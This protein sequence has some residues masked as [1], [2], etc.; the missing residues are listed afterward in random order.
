MNFFYTIG[1]WKNGTDAPGILSINLWELSPWIPNVKKMISNLFPKSFLTIC[2]LILI[3]GCT[4]A[5]E[6]IAYP[7]TDLSSA[8]LIPKPLKVVPTGSAFGLDNKTAIHTPLQAV[9]LKR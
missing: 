1:I 9:D 6:K 8:N 7:E 2:A 5:P 4:Q 3:G